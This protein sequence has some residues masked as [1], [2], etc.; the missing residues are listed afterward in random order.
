MVIRIIQKSMIEELQELL[1]YVSSSSSIPLKRTRG[2]SSSNEIQVSSCLV[3]GCDS[4]LTKC[5]DCHRRHKVCET[6]SKTPKVT[7]EGCEQCF[8]QQCS[9]CVVVDVHLVV[10]PWTRESCGFGF[11]TMSKLEEAECCFKY[12]DRTNLWYSL[13][14]LARALPIYKHASFGLVTCMQVFLEKLACCMANG[15]ASSSHGRVTYT[16]IAE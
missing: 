6:H 12:L 13:D 4:D 7:I 16:S 15:Y 10:Y 5:W 3:D 1:Y 11:V 9:S 8:C 14:I 2:L